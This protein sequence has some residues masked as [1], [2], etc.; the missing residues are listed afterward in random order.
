MVRVLT[1][2]YYAFACYVRWEG[3]VYKVF[4][5]LAKLR[6][7][8]GEMCRLYGKFTSHVRRVLFFF[9]KMALLLFRK[10][11]S[12]LSFFCSILLR[13]F[14]ALLSVLFLFPSFLVSKG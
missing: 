2:A 4:L 10:R 6:L 3:H 1:H 11:F 8:L 9:V 14:T 7:I 13:L 5:V 12:S